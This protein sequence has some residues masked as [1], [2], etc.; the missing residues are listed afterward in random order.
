MSLGSGTV[1]EYGSSAKSEHKSEAHAG[2]PEVLKVFLNP[3]LTLWVKF[4]ESQAVLVLLSLGPMH[5]WLTY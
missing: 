3:E 4:L 2:F 5:S 1:R